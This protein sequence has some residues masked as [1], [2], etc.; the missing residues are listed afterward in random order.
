MT[1]EDK[2]LAE[3][4]RMRDAIKSERADVAH[5]TA[6]QHMPTTHGAKGWNRSGGKRARE[7]EAVLSLGASFVFSD[8]GESDSED[9]GEE[10]ADGES[11]AQESPPAP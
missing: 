7:E 2:T 6:G 3:A 9:G 10:D 4:G 5:A 1:P 11:R 8:S